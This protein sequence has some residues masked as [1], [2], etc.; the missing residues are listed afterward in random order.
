MGLLL[1]NCSAVLHTATPNQALL[2]RSGPGLGSH[3][4]RRSEEVRSTEV[5]DQR[6]VRILGFGVREAGCSHGRGEQKAQEWGHMCR[7]EHMRTADDIC[8]GKHRMF[9]NVSAGLHVFSDIWNFFPF[10]V[11]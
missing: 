1:T 2:L 5:V 9:F 11:V 7:Q 6:C 3:F 10:L 4:D 8:G